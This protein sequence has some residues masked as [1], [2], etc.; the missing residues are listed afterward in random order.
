V[1]TY[2]RPYEIFTLWTVLAVWQINVL[3]DTADKPLWRNL[4]LL[5]VAVAGGLLTHYQFGLVVAVLGVW[6]LTTLWRRDRRRCLVIA[7]C[8]ESGVATFLIVDNVHR[9]LFPVVLWESQDDVMIYAASQ[10][11]LLAHAEEWIVALDGALYLS[12]Y[13]YRSSDE[14]R[15]SIVTLIEKSY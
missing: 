12:H 11:Y 14:D 5:I 2:A 13:A 15:A 1:S 8:I 4:L 3:A 6:S 10:R 7:A 9:G